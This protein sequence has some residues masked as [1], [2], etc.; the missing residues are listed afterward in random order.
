M[1]LGRRPIG[2]RVQPATIFCLGHL[3][4]I[5]MHQAIVF[6]DRTY[7]DDLLFHV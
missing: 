7:L 6:S 1:Q 4:V 2:Y 3:K 5:E